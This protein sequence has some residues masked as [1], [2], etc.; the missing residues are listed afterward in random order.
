MR[1]FGVV[2]E[3]TVAERETAEAAGATLLVGR[4]A[5]LALLLERWAQSQDGRGQVVLVSGE[6][7]IGKPQPGNYP[8]RAQ[9]ITGPNHHRR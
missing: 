2:R 7:G 4:D 5:E 9:R 3:R 8:Y 6:A 1:V